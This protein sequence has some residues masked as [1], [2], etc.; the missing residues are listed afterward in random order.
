MPKARRGRLLL[1]RGLPGFACL[2]VLLV[3]LVVPSSGR[4]Q[5]GGGTGTQGR[6]GGTI[7]TDDGYGASEG[8]LSTQQQ[9]RSSPAL[10]PRR[11]ITEGRAAV[12][13]VL[14]MPTPPPMSLAQVSPSLQQGTPPGGALTPAPPRPSRRP[15]PTQQAPASVGTPAPSAPSADGEVSPGEAEG[16]PPEAG[17]EPSRPQ[18]RAKMQMSADRNISMAAP[19][20][21]GAR[22]RKRQ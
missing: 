5:P 9:V 12:P 21:H 18:G 22:I 17:P 11:V 13:G 15:A 4:S 19:L 20:S 14:P 1:P 3:L 10:P 8:D 6:S 2:V 7:S 16:R